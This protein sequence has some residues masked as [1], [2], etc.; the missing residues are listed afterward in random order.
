[1][2]SSIVTL[3]LFIYVMPGMKI[4]YNIN[5][6]RSNNC[7]GHVTIRRPICAGLHSFGQLKRK[8]HLWPIHVSLYPLSQ[9]AM[10]LTRFQ[11]N[12]SIHFHFSLNWGPPFL[13]TFR[14]HLWDT[15]GF[16]DRNKNYF[17]CLCALYSIVIW[18]DTFFLKE[19]YYKNANFS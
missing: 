12:L 16:R 10:L 6:S 2:K 11:P 19:K 8:T 17:N 3:M 7:F 9:L 4:T 1:M 18:Y 5:N 15:K 13:A 14:V